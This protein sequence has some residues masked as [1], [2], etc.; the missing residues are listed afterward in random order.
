MGSLTDEY[1]FGRHV[2]C[3]PGAGGA[4][5]VAAGRWS[6]LA[7]GRPSGGAVGLPLVSNQVYCDIKV[8]VIFAENKAKIFSIAV[9]M[10]KI[11]NA[12]IGKKNET[13]YGNNML[14]LTHQCGA[15]PL[16]PCGARRHVFPLS[17]LPPWQ[18]YGAAAPHTAPIPGA[19]FDR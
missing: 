15:A 11:L 12:V 14:D 19:G 6:A 3:L 17:A 9:A 10:V 2:A 8:E 4:S 7:S 16:L 18:A 5:P 1:F 13:W